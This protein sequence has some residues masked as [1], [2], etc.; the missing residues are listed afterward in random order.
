MEKEKID[1]ILIVN[2]N[3]IGDVLFSTPAIRALRKH[4]PGAHIACMVV[5]RCE[6]I[7]ELN[8]H[9]NELIIYDEKG[10]NKGLIGKLKLISELRA[11]RFDCVF[12]FHRSLTRTLM[13]ALSGIRE[14]VGIDNP[15]RGFLLTKKIKPQP[16][17]IHKVEQFLNIVK[18]ITGEDDGKSMELFT[19]KEDEAFAGEFLKS[20]GIGEGDRFII[21][22][23]GGNWDPKRWPAV[24]FAGLGDRLNE[25]YKVPIIITGAQKDVELANKISGIMKHKPVIAA[26]ETTIRQLAAIMKRASLVI[27]NDS[28]PMH[29]AVSQGARTI[30]IFGP[31]DPKITGPYGE[32]IYGVIQ[33]DSGK[34]GC[35]IPCYDLRCEEAL[36]MK[37]VTV[38]DVML[39]AEK[40]LKWKT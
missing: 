24:D 29:I 20:H 7:L 26:G 2:V 14:R 37:A 6:E 28:G 10:R 35:K 27:S 25:K 19:G 15:K 38:E 18:V 32:G 36:C 16:S 33:K 3:W 11:R 40:L 13:V 4:F 8:P 30:A 12:L 5:P 17:D 39:E 22:N 1:K 9:L 21:L 23:P 31:T 34:P